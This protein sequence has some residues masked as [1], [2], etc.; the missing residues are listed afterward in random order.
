MKATYG[1]NAVQISSAHSVQ[2]LQLV[3]PA[4]NLTLVL[5]TSSS[6][7]PTADKAPSR[8]VLVDGAMTQK[9]MALQQRMAVRR[10]ER[11]RMASVRA[12]MIS[13][14]AVTAALLV[15]I[16]V[17]YSAVSMQHAVAMDSASA[18]SVERIQV[19]PGESLWQI[20]Q[21]H[22]IKGVS[23]QETIDYIMSI[24]NL[25][26]EN[27]QAGVMLDVPVYENR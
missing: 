12:T 1:S 7:Q 10:Q 14:A 16:A 18:V 20:A 27:L 26:H 4:A 5:P 3:S 6:K 9:R 25:P 13:I 8:L 23:T 15:F 19:Q 21:A 11:M 24:N 2:H 22:P 17:I